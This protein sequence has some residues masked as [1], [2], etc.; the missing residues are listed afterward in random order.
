METFCLFLTFL[1]AL[2]PFFFV[3]LFFAHV[4]SYP[5]YEYTKKEFAHKGPLSRLVTTTH[6][7]NPFNS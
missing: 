6:P 5:S 7:S 1:T 2:I 4:R 3:C